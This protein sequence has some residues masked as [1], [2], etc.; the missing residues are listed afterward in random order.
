MAKKDRS[1]V[2]LIISFLISSVFSAGLVLASFQIIPGLVNIDPQDE[3][4]LQG[5]EKGIEY[6]IKNQ[7]KK[8]M[9]EYQKAQKEKEQALNNIPKTDKPQV[10]LFVMSHCPYGLQM[11]KG[12]IPAIET[13]GD[14]VNFQVKFCDY[15]MHGQKELDEQTLQHCIMQTEG[16]KYLSYLKCFIQSGETDSCLAEVAISRDNL[17]NCIASTDSQYK[18]N[19][20]YQNKTGEWKGEF[21]PF[22]IFKAEN[23][24]YKIQGSPS[25]VINGQEVDSGRDSHNLLKTI[26][27]GF[28]N[29]PAE[30]EASLDS[31]SPAAGF[32]GEATAN[33]AADAS[34]G[35]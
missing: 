35:A 1:T 10:E 22:D 4:F 12:I 2:K 34:C 14:K 7:E 15:A 25:L 29:P 28:Q 26:C 3:K 17:Q 6:Y 23:Q 32:G 31:N 5:V 16:S 9:E 11:E 8:Q 20:N 24:K 30:C 19:E 27:R 18:I 33:N 13:L 21:P